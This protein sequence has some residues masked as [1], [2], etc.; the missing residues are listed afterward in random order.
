MKNDRHVPRIAKEFCGCD[1]APRG[2][3]GI[4]FV[5]EQGGVV[6]HV[7]CERRLH[8]CRR[9]VVHGFDGPKADHKRRGGGRHF[10]DL[11]VNLQSFDE[12]VRKIHCHRQHD[13]PPNQI[14][15]N[16]PTM[17]DN[18]RVIDDCKQP[19]VDCLNEQKLR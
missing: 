16:G 14:G 18:E 10:K 2:R 15:C 12:H 6:R 11:V 17:F 19:L 7:G 1:F 3:F 4:P 5:V 13:T 9:R 8:G